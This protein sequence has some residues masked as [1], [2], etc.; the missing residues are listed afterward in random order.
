MTSFQ[1]HK[2]RK[3]ERKGLFREGQ[4]R[5][6]RT[7]MQ[8]CL[9]PGRGPPTNVPP[10]GP[11]RASDASLVHPRHPA[12]SSD[13]PFRLFL[14]PLICLSLNVPRTFYSKIQQQDFPSSPSPSN[15]DY[16][17]HSHDQSA[18]QSLCHNW[19]VCRQGPPLGVVRPPLLIVHW[20]RIV[21]QCATNNYLGLCFKLSLSFA[22][23]E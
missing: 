5:L 13:K 2:E 18:L 17:S 23:A 20:G 22:F 4:S 21:L 11:D 9:H 6:S 16:P 3:K 12:A 10:S 14:H 1:L 7:K 8:V 19:G 15:D